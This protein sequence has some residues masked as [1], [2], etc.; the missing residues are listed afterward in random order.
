MNSE[1]V[2]KK[3][4]GCPSTE[5]ELLQRAQTIEGMS[6]AQI[7]HMLTIAIP[8][9]PLKRKG[10]IGQAIEM[11]LGATAGSQA[12]PDFNHLGIELKTLPI[13]KNGKPAEST[14]VTSI[15]LLTIQNE[16]WRTS[17]CYNKL[18][19][20]L[21]I[22][23]ESDSMIP[24][25]HRRIGQ[26]NLWS[27]NLKQEA[28]LEQDWIELS[29]LISSGRVAELSASMGEYLQVRP[30]CANKKSLCYGYNELGEKIQTLPRGF[31]LRSRFT[32]TLF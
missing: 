7:A 23:V 11:A 5:K 26:A 31:Y 6:L 13:K 27:P 1:S 14:F 19:R 15:S 25:H 9:S 8:T 22:P 29:W 16:Q 24:F 20:I 17:Q 3:T 4:F 21:W 32:A 18:K 10:W 12:I 28:V 2:L 30:K